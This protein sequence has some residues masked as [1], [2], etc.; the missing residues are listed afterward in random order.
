MGWSKEVRKAGLAMDVMDLQSPPEG[1]QSTMMKGTL[2]Q[3]NVYG[4]Q[5]ALIQGLL[6]WSSLDRPPDSALHIGTNRFRRPPRADAFPSA[7]V[8]NGRAAQSDICIL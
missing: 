4:G 5:N 6:T 8:G 1:H 2:E 3:L 7:E